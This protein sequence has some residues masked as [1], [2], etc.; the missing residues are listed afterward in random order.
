ML[1]F[2]LVGVGALVLADG[3]QAE[4]HS[5]N[6]CLNFRE[7]TGIHRLH[8]NQTFREGRCNI[9]GTGLRT[10]LNLAAASIF[11]FPLIF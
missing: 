4:K 9:L 10:G 3:M 1:E 11:V 8:L 5:L 7:D 6:F 2:E